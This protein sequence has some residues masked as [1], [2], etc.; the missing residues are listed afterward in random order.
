MSRTTPFLRCAIALLC[1]AAWASSPAAAQTYHYGFC[2]GVAGY[3]P[4]NYVTRAFELKPT[5][6]DRRI[7]FMQALDKEHGG[8]VRRDAT[9]CRMFE[10]AAE[11]ATAH[12]QLLEQ[13]RRMG[14]K[15]VGLTWL[16]TSATALPAAGT[17][18]TAAAHKPR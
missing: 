11:A 6:A 13:T 4:V 14:T 9:G 10:T 3:P 7:E 16:P 18:D 15:F 5:G 17:S 2:L 8:N 12:G 1:I